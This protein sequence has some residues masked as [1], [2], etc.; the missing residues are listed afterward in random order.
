MFYVWFTLWLLAISDPQVSRPTFF[1]PLMFAI[2]IR[3]GYLNRGLGIMNWPTVLLA[4]IMTVAWATPS[5]ASG[6]NMGL[7]ILVWSALLI[8]LAEAL[9]EF[10][11]QKWVQLSFT[12]HYWSR[13]A[14]LV[15]PRRTENVQCLVRRFK[16][17][18]FV[19]KL[20]MV[21]GTATNVVAEL[22]SL[23]NQLVIVLRSKGSVPADL[24][25]WEGR[26]ERKVFGWLPYKTVADCVL[27]FLLLLPVLGSA[28][29][30]MPKVHDLLGR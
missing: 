22:A 25:W 29:V 15:G 4:G 23:R 7:R 10:R 26:S 11:V 9:A 19:G 2:T 18:S 27:L 28:G 24:G 12:L 30:F 3:S 17:E 6:A 21:L 16:S 20:W 8:H 1:L 14:A 5:W 13:V